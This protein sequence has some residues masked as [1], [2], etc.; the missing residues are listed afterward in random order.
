MHQFAGLSDTL[1]RKESHERATWRIMAQGILHDRN[2]F[3]SYESDLLYMAK[4]I[5]EFDPEYSFSPGV[6]YNDFCREC[7]QIRWHMRRIARCA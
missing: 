4:K 7:S 2:V 5:K 6:K 3:G 1:S